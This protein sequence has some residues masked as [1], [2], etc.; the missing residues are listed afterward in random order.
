MIRLVHGNRWS[1]QKLIREFREFWRR[2][3]N[4]L[5]PLSQSGSADKSLQAEGNEDEEAD[6]SQ[7]EDMNDGIKYS[8]S[9][10]QVDKT[11]KEIAVY[12]RRSTYS[13]S[14]WYVH[15]AFLEK[16]DLMDLTV[17]TQWV[18]VTK[19]PNKTTTRTATPSNNISA[20]VAMTAVNGS[21][22]VE[23]SPTPTQNIQ[24]EGS[25][26][27]FTKPGISPKFP[28]IPPK[29]TACSTPA[30]QGKGSI[31][32]KFKQDTPK[33]DS[34]QQR[35]SPAALFQPIDKAE[36]V[37]STDCTIIDVEIPISKPDKNQP[38]LLSLLKG[39]LGT[40]NSAKSSS[41]KTVET[42]R[43]NCLNSLTSNKNCVISDDKVKTATEE[44]SSSTIGSSQELVLGSAECPMEID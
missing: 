24:K 36:E 10:R 5:D 30:A 11:I 12:E 23:R 26:M 17:P 43:E 9:K 44:N 19:D 8:M 40:A 41:P 28:V 4:G 20:T 21:N 7:N 25:I 35:M 33:R 27:K 31:L 6:T 15:D 39:N 42:A 16:A 34:L 37:T 29:P 14:C 3:S 2:K 22:A 1:V 13:K 18:W 38:T 32:S